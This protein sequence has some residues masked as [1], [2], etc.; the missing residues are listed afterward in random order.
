MVQPEMHAA[1]ALHTSCEPH[2][3]PTGLARWA[4]A[5]LPS[6]WSPVQGLPSS[7]HAAPAALLTTLQPPLPSQV[8]L[9]WHAVAVQA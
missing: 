1:L 6:H 2:A 8:E 7:G 3:V 5:P 4:Q 9:A